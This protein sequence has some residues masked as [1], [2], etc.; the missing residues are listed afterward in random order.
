MGIV[1]YQTTP[2]ALNCLLLQLLHT[3][4]T[5]FP[6]NQFETTELFLTC[7]KLLRTMSTEDL[8]WE[9][10]LGYQMKSQM[11]HCKTSLYCWQT[12]KWQPFSQFRCNWMQMFLESLWSCTPPPIVRSVS[13]SEVQTLSNMCKEIL[14]W[15]QLNPL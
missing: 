7:Q 5:S 12:S 11:A 15:V 13:Y 2:Y 3:L 8:N 1:L 4:P 9:I 10:L 14:K 6:W